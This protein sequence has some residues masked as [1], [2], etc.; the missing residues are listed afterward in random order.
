MH[1]STLKRIEQLVI[2]LYMFSPFQISINSSYFLSNVGMYCH[3]INLSFYIGEKR[4]VSCVL[5]SVFINLWVWGSGEECYM[6]EE[7]RQEAVY[8]CG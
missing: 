3:T 1:K 2:C 8:H 5:F 7:A 6:C 4:C